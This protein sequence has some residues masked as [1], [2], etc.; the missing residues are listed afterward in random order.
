MDRYYRD[1]RLRQGSPSPRPFSNFGH[2]RI[3]TLI[4]LLFGISCWSSVVWVVWNCALAGFLN[5]GGVGPL[6]SLASGT[7]L[8]TLSMLFD[9]T[10]PGR[11]AETFERPL[12]IK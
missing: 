7:I 9:D 6:Q 1:L 5:A 2:K 10:E 3:N 4:R 8:Y 11:R 12:R